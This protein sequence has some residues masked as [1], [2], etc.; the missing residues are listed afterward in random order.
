MPGNVSINLEDHL[1]YNSSAAFD[2]AD[3][4]KKKPYGVPQGSVLEP[5]LFSVFFYFLNVFSIVVLIKNSFNVAVSAV[6]N[7]HPSNVII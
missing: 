6:N 2:T 1:W 4:A 7:I 5:L 3:T